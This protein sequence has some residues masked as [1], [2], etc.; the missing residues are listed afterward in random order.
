MNCLSRLHRLPRRRPVRQCGAEILLTPEGTVMNTQRLR[1]WLSLLAVVRL[2]VAPRLVA[3]QL[4]DDKNR[5]TI[6]LQDGMQ[7]VLVGVAPLR[8][9]I[10]SKNKYYYLPTNL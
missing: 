1:R 3:E 8:G 2:I 7:V 9:S 6:R 10:P 4:F 5:H